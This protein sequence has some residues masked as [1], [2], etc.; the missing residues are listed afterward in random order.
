MAKT[1]V[2][3]RTTDLEPIDRLEEKLKLLVSMITQLKA[4]Q[5]KAA[6][7]NARLTEELGD[8]RARLAD[9]EATSNAELGVLREE[10]ELIR[11]R[12]ADMLQQLE[13]I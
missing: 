11:T 2:A 9:A 1:A 7:E 12:V 8:L 5:A 13:G 10:R 6:A 4:E 3:A